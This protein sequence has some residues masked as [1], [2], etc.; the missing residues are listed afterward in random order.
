MAAKF[1]LVLEILKELPF[2]RLQRNSIQNE[3]MLH[4]FRRENEPAFIQFA[5]E[6]VPWRQIGNLTKIGRSQLACRPNNVSVFTWITD[7]LRPNFQP[8]WIFRLTRRVVPGG[9]ITG[10]GGSGVRAAGAG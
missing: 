8:G 7:S 6:Q 4:V 3:G 1:R 9:L 10:G 2:T 5:N